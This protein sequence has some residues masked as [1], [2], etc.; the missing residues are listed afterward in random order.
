MKAFD[1]SEYDR[2]KAEAQQR[3]GNTDTYKEHAERTRNYPKDKWNGLAADMDLIFGEFSL[4][5][6]NGIRPDEEATQSLVKR[7][8]EHIT[9][10]YYT[11]TSEILAGLGQMYA[12]DERF[13][14][15]IDKH[16]VGTAAFVSEA[17]AIYSKRQ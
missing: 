17:I 11:C 8:Q 2:Y 4:C 10:N 9:E 13:K 6:K 12:A 1:N 14:N 16:A 5:V 7:L 3:W 15:N